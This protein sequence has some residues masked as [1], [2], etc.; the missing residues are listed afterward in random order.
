MP[1]PALVLA[2]TILAQAGLTRSFF[3]EGEE[4]IVYT[5]RAEMDRTGRISS[6]PVASSFAAFVHYQKAT[7]AKDLRLCQEMEGRGDVYSVESGTRCH[8]AP[9]RTDVGRPS[10]PR[11]PRD[12]TPERP[13][14]GPGWMDRGRPISVVESRITV[15]PPERYTEDNWDTP[16]PLAL[17]FQAQDKVIYRELFAALGQTDDRRQGRVARDRQRL[18][19]QQ[20]FQREHQAVLDRYGLDDTTA[21]RIL[22]WGRQG[23]WPTQVPDDAAKSDQ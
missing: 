23:D 10:R 14:Q 19:R 18:L 2:I 22:D 4:V 9:R 17:A 5:Y 7:H 11:R 20:V 3:G 12:P 15:E 1:G 13:P 16:R 6:L 8:V 21:L